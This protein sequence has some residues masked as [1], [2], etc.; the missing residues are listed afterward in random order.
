MCSGDLTLERAYKHV[1]G[2]LHNK[3]HDLTL[4]VH[5]CKDWGQII[6]FTRANIAGIETEE[7]F[8]AEH[9]FP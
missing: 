4:A 1:H 5:T 2:V 3:T 8:E 6:D 7:D 9:H